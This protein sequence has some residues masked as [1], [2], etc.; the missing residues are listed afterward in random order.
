[1]K[2]PLYWPQIEAIKL[3]E[4]HLDGRTGKTP[5]IRSSRQTTKNEVSAMV[6]DR[7]L[8]RYKNVGGSIVKIAP[9]YRPQIVNSKRRLDE[10]I[11]VDPLI[12]PKPRGYREGYIKEYGRVSIQFLSADKTANVEGATASLLLEV[13]EAHHIDKLKFEE[14]FGPMTAFTAAAT[15]MYGVAA[16]KMDLLYEQRLYNQE[17]DPGLN[18]QY[19]A[20]IWCELIPAYEKHYTER[21]D[22]LG[23]D[24]PIILTQYDLVDIESMGG[25]LKTHQIE[26]ILTSDHQRQ[27]TP[28]G[29]VTY[30]C[31]IDIGGEDDNEGEVLADKGEAAR[32]A[33]S[34][35]IVEVDHANRV[36]DY[37]MLRVVQGHY[38]VGKIMGATPAGEKGQQE[39]LL[40]ILNTWRPRKVV[41]DARG[42]GLQIAQYLKK[43]YASVEDYTASDT[44]VSND[45]YGF[46]ALVNNARVKMWQNDS[47]EE[48]I[49]L[50][51]ELRHTKSEIVQHDKM[52]LKKPQGG[53]HIDMVKALTYLTHCLKKPF[54][55]STY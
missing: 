33:T 9:T 49:E 48:W 3:I 55:M 47:S 37:P 6:E 5:T 26:S 11:A 30:A 42:L 32:D 29:G 21:V 51:Q 23:K 52:K 27:F 38:W 45:C 43:R 31:V 10:M 4:K 34:C 17:H 15:V 22:K 35:W 18:L 19:P 50:Q 44:S 36:Y 8:T 14:A 16:A 12:G 24:H 54:V 53:G 40:D 46:L 25:F 41:V 2:R 20:A 1:M 28:R 7:A 39:I 13:D